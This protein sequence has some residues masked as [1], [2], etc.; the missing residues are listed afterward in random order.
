[1]GSPS[2][3]GRAGESSSTGEVRNPGHHHP[4][5]LEQCTLQLEM[6]L[7]SSEMEMKSKISTIIK[8]GF[9][10]LLLFLVVTRSSL[11]SEI[12]RERNGL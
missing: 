10:P 7:C 8:T 2:T 1:M 9:R 4:S 6:G 12:E 11:D 3:G 5:L